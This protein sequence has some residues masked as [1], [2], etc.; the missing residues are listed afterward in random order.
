MVSNTF[1]LQ[2]P[3]IKF[4]NT[5]MRRHIRYVKE[6]NMMVNID[7]NTPKEFLIYIIE[8]ILNGEPQG[9]IYTEIGEENFFPI[10]I[11]DDDIFYHGT[12]ALLGS[13]IKE[14]GLCVPRISGMEATHGGIY[15]EYIYIT[16]N[17]DQ[18]KMWAKGP[19][20][21]DKSTPIII[22]IKG[23]DIIE[24]GCK[25]FV[26]T[27]YFTYPTTAILLKGCNCIKIDKI[28]DEIF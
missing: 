22:T 24:A 14:T 1:T 9:D 11:E 26:D 23:K 19:S 13:I 10:T 28:L 4:F 12:S 2:I 17:K 21:V 3:I 25:A 8:N 27:F 7:P 5:L 16:N 6:N 18:A 20:S 15:S